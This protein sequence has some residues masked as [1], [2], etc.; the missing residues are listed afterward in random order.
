MAIDIDSIVAE[1][2]R[3]G[4]TAKKRP[5]VQQWHPARAGEI[6]IVIDRH[7][8]W[9]HEGGR[10]ERQ[11]LVK[12]LASILRRDGDDYFLVT[13]AEKLKIR[14]EDVPF[15]IVSL[16]Q[17]PGQPL[18]LV[19]NVEDL[20][21]LDAGCDWQLRPYDGVLVP[22]VRVRDRL[23]ARIDRPVYYQMMAMAREQS[24][25]G[26]TAFY[27]DSAGS[28]FLLGELTDDG[29]DGISAAPAP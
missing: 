28:A 5:P 24:Q 21:S 14:V 7:N 13:P 27:L 9:L 2:Q 18:Q 20:V 16:L 26:K 25:D 4:G 22:Y 10:F 17:R 8:G 12:L 3:D 19:S 29:E 23:Y 1:L 6:D 15:R 11:A